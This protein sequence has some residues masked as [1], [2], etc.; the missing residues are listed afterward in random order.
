VTR[1]RDGTPAPTPLA[2]VRDRDRLLM[3]TAAD[4]AKVRRL[5]RDSSVVVAPCDLR[6]RPLG[7]GVPARARL[8]SS[9]ADRNAA[10]RAITARYGLAGRIWSAL[11]RAARLEAAY[12]EVTPISP[13]S[14]AIGSLPGYD[15][16]DRW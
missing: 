1:R 16:P 10:E 7:A 5:R 8:L 6:G 12:I 13:R 9:A 2:F 3:R 14:E 11:V 15:R 4:S